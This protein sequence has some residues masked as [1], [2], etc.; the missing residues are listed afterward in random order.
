[1]DTQQKWYGL[2]AEAKE[3]IKNATPNGDG[4]E[5][6]LTPDL[7]ALERAI[8]RLDPSYPIS[9]GANSWWPEGGKAP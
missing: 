2:L 6:C 7:E 3:V 5:T 8:Y 4:T 1:M 9:V